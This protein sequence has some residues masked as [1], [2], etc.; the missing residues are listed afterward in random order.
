MEV[1]P[2]RTR[3]E[4]ASFVKL[5]FKLYRGDP[6]WV[7]PLISQRKR[8]LD[9]KKN[10]F[11]DHGEAQYFLALREGD[12]VGRISASVDGLY[13][14]AQGGKDGMFGQF[15]CVDSFEVASALI[16]Q[17]Q[18][19]LKGRGRERMLGPLGFSTS[20]DD[21]G[22]LIEGYEKPPYVMMPYGK[23]YY[24]GLLEREGLVKSV[25][26]LQYLLTDESAGGFLPVLEE[27]SE[28]AQKEHGVVI[29]QID[30]GDFEAELSRFFDLYNST[31]ERNWG[32][33]PLTEAEL[34]FI[35]KDLKPVLDSRLV[36]FAERE[37]EVMGGALCL[38]NINEILPKLKGRLLPTGWIRLFTGLHKIK[39]MRVFTLGVKP[40]YQHTGVAAALYI[41]IRDRGLE[42]GIEEAEQ[43]WIL[44]INEPM[45]RAME[46]MGG[47]IVKRYRIFEKS[48]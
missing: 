43:G 1:V 17:A 9:Q 18:E 23:R 24:Q 15:E 13:D 26:L 40:E 39:T 36:L 19:W 33:V 29:R 42:I 6:N 21:C 7:P 20:H 3:H 46:A 16:A 14:E 22:L 47:E 5:P 11:F 38:P 44:E 28:K 10:P 30:K 25:D 32:F 12:L 48:L 37:G 45:V 4:L 31:W 2:V 34:R 35:A 41:A 27:L 8:F